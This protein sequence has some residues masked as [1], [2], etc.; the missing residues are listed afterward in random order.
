MGWIW[1]DRLTRGLPPHTST[2]EENMPKTNNPELTGRLA[3]LI[4]ELDDVLD[5]LRE[6]QDPTDTTPTYEEFLV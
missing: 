5:K 3:D 6:E 1:Q 2:T 4:D